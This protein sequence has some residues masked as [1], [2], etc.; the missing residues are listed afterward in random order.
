MR[1]IAEGEVGWGAAG[2]EVF[3]YPHPTALRAAT[4]PARGGE[5]TA[6]VRIKKFRCQDLAP[7]SIKDEGA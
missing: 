4:L 2:D 5:E 3:G 1:S 7:R 6:F